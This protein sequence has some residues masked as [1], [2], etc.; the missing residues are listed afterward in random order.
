ML[1]LLLKLPYFLIKRQRLMKASDHYWRKKMQGRQLKI[2][3][4]TLDPRAQG[5]FELQEKFSAPMAKWTPAMLR[6]GYNKSVELFDGP[7]APVSS[8]EDIDI[9]LPGRTIRG[10]FYGRDKDIDGQA[11]LLYFHGG[12]FVIGDLESHDRL[13]RKLANATGQPVLAIDYRLGPENRYPAAMEDALDCWAWLQTAASGF[14][15]SPARISV[16]GDSAGAALALLIAAEASK[17]SMGHKPI[18]AGLIY[19]PHTLIEQTSSRDLLSGENIVLTQELMDWFGANFMPEELA[20]AEKYLAPLGAAV[21]GEVA[22]TWILTCG[23]D[24]LRDDGK[25]IAGLLEDLETD[26]SI[27]EYEDLYH[28][29]IGASALFSKVDDMVLDLA[30]FLCKYDSAVERTAAEQA[31]E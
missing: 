14:G 20:N 29:F 9:A 3:G 26:V 28:G 13:C 21:A 8:V 2:D 22:P 31:A 16:A 4:R 24:P 6:A 12:G 5:L 19:P 23:F 10:R 30:G 15:F 17:G 7:K 11:C 25:Y 27:Q 18:A 1:K